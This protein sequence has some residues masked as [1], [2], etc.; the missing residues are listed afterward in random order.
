M[1]RDHMKSIFVQIVLF[2]VQIY[3][4]KYIIPKIIQS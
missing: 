2:F 1:H 3:A 4:K